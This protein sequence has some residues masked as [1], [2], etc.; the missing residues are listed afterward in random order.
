MPVKKILAGVLVGVYCFLAP[1]GWA[2]TLQPMSLA[3][4]VQ[5]ADII[6]VGT[7]V[8]RVS[9]WNPEHTRIYTRTTFQ[10]EEYLKGY[11]G[12]TIVVETMGGV[13]EGVGMMVPGMP[14]FSVNQQ[15]LL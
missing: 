11:A 1:N 6:F 9:A 10:L 12:E 5:E 14:V 3:E 8:T 4:L 15:E 7:A 13:A 2:V